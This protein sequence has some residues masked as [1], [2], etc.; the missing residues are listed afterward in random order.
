MRTAGVAI[1]PV[2]EIR[3]VAHDNNHRYYGNVSIVKSFTLL[4][5][6]MLSLLK[7]VYLNM[8]S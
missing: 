3:N 5:A 7:E 4:H 2:K 8:Q 1:A 6:S